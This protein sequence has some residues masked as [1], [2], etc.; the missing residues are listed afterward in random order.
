MYLTLQ[1][2]SNIGM[3]TALNIFTCYIPCLRLKWFKEHDHGYLLGI[4]VLSLIFEETNPR[5]RGFL[6]AT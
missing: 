5:D 2:A 4:A 3:K 6:F 1:L